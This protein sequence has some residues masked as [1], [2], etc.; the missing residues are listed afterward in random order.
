MPTDDLIKLARLFAELANIMTLAFEEPKRRTDWVSATHNLAKLLLSAASIAEPASAAKSAVSAYPTAKQLTAAI[1]GIEDSAPENLAWTW[2]SL[3][4]ADA[5]TNFLKELRGFAIL[6]ASELDAAVKAFIEESLK[7][8]DSARLDENAF[9]SPATHPA[10][11]QARSQVG[12]L[13]AKVTLKNQ[14]D[15]PKWRGVFDDCIASASFRAIASNHDKL[16]SL[17][18]TVTGPAGTALRKNVAWARH[19]EWLSKRF[20]QDAVFSP[21]GTVTAPL[22]ELY[23]RLRTYWHEVREEPSNDREEPEKRWKA[24]LGDLHE[25]V[26]VWLDDESDNYLK[27]IAGGP[28]SGKSSFARA[29]AAETAQRGLRR[30]L[31]IELQRMTL[32]GDLYQDIGNY[33]YQ[34]NKPVGEGGS[35]GF[36]ENPLDWLKGDTRP[37]L[38]VFDGLDEITHDSAKAKEIS[39]NFVLNTEKL[40]RGQNQDGMRISALILGRDAACQEGMKAAGLPLQTMLNV[41]P[42]RRLTKEDLDPINNNSSFK[43]SVDYPEM[44]SCLVCDQRPEYWKLWC[45]SQ[46]LTNDGVPEAITNS[47]LSDLNVEPLLLHLLILSDYCG[48]RWKEAAENRN[49][50]Y[51]DILG[52]I[53]QRNVKEKK[54]GQRLKEDEFFLLMECLGLAAWRGNL[55]TGTEP[56]YLAVREIHARVMQKTGQFDHADMDSMVLQTHARKVD[57]VEPGFEFIHKSFGEYLAA[58]ALVTLAQRTMR[59]L[60]NREDPVGEHVVATEWVDLIDAS[61][62]TPEILRFVRDEVRQISNPTD[63]SKLRSS[64]QDLLAWTIKNGLPAKGESFRIIETIQRCAETALLAVGASV[65]LL[66]KQADPKEDTL[67]FGWGRVDAHLMLNRLGAAHGTCITGALTALDFSDSILPVSTLSNA[68]MRFINLRRAHLDQSHFNGTNFQGAELHQASLV[69][70]RAFDANFSRAD[71]SEADLMGAKLHQADFVGAN[72]QMTDLR[73]AHLQRVAFKDARLEG[74]KL[75]SSKLE[76]SNFEGADLNDCEFDMASAISVDF[77]GSRNLTQ[78]AVDSMFGVKKGYGLTKLPKGI[79]YPAFWHISKDIENPSGEE[80]SELRMG[81]EKAFGEWTTN[82]VEDFFSY[83]GVF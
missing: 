61:E 59:R 71:L 21:D 65:S 74:A 28:G 51:R 34:R 29:I 45:L 30:V 33:L 22:S 57:G 78:E 9:S 13:I 7:I 64:I 12:H 39:R 75:G 67:K 47:A 15:I 3:T 35:P 25:T 56:T 50:V 36:V 19:Y 37:A 40:V 80:I 42:I 16:A 18:E 14:F 41:A 69:L 2:L 27:V 49:L 62:L 32:T 8:P 79:N 20:Y 11:A 70:V 76:H 26:E 48:P 38:I 72:L 24:H 66:L 60:Q 6:Q 52:Q 73:A 81:Y 17:V 43:N 4:L 44:P 58:R 68:D 55:R 54:P 82:N 83:T 23:L 10:F 1:K 77:S 53:H 31:F 5:L 46:K 63:L